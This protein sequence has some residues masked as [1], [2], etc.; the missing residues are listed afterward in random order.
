MIEWSERIPRSVPPEALVV[1]ITVMEDGK[2]RIDTLPAGPGG[3]G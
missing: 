3:R 2:R 1:E